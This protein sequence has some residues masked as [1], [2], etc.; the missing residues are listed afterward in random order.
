MK[1][2]FLKALIL[3]ILVIVA[4]NTLVFAETLTYGD[5]QY[6]TEGAITDYLG[7]D[8]IIYVPSEINGTAITEIATYAFSTSSTTKEVIIPEG[9]TEIGSAAFS[10]CT[11]LTSVTIPDSVTAIGRIAFSSCTSLE[12]IEIPYGITV[13]EDSTFAHCSS[14]VSVTIPSTVKTIEE[15]AFA[16]CTSL[17]DVEIPYGVTTLG[18]GSF[19]GSTSIESIIIPNSVRTMEW[20]VFAGCSGLT[21]V[22]ITDA[23]DE[24]SPYTFWNCTSL[25]SVTIPSNIETVSA[26]SFYGC[27]NLTS[28]TMLEGVKYINVQAFQNC[29]SL[30]SIMLPSTIKSISQDAFI[31]CDNFTDIYYSGTLEDS[32]KISVFGTNVNYL[33]ATMTFLPPETV[34][35]AEPTSAKVLVNGEE[36]TFEAYEINN[37]NYFKLRDIAMVLSGT[38]KQ[39]DITWSA[40][41]GITLIA[42]Q[43]YTVV[44]GELTAGDNTTKIYET[45]TDTIYKGGLFVNLTAYTINSNNYFKLRDLGQL[46]NFNVSW[47]NENSIIIINTSEAYTLD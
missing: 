36:I 40:D 25:A 15:Y 16:M 28:V 17:T 37:N 22:V 31:G 38:E 27:T 11:N 3:S 19:N 14:L 18:K 42:N 47:D 8:E 23:I 46:F 30:T 24:L 32:L 5:F 34:F 35:L 13:I 2:K 9:I 20:S 26:N 39:F 10:Y 4:T 33:N 21:D 7:S 43:A 1:N 6:N 41:V 12:S 45:N 29:T 44:G